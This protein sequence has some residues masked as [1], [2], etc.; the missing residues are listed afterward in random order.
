[1]GP[2]ARVT[3]SEGLSAWG[4]AG[5]GTGDMTIPMPQVAAGTQARPDRVPH[6]RTTGR[7]ECVHGTT[8]SPV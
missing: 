1:M 2:Y 4:L 6:N 5:F 7:L 3:V 8:K